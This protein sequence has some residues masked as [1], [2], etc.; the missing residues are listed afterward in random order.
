MQPKQQLSEAEIKI[1]MNRVIKEGLTA[2]TVTTLTSGAFLVA[3]ALKLGAS[4]FQIGILASLPTICN[5][6][7]LIAI[8]FLQKYR[9]RRIISA[10]SAFLARLPL[11]V[12]ALLPFV[13][14]PQIS[15]I[16]LISMLFL[17]FFF[18]T[19]T[20]LSWNSWMK[21]LIPEAK[22]GTYF[23]QRSRLIQ[24]LNVTISVSVA[25]SLDHI[26]EFFPDY[27]LLTYSAMFLLASLIGFLGVYLFARTPEPKMDLSEEINI[28]SFY[29]KPL[30]DVNFRNFL[31]FNSTWAF[32]TNLAI[33][34]FAVYL[35][36]TLHLKLSLIIGLN[37]LSQISSILFIK[38]WGKYCD[39]FSNKTILSFCAP[40]YIAS[41]LIWPYTTMPESHSLTIYLLLVIYGLIGI[42]SAGINLS[43]ANIG[44]KLTPKAETVTYLS[45]RSMI[46]AFFTAI[47][48]IIGGLFAD[49][50]SG[51]KLTWN[52]EWKGTTGNY[53][54]PFI[55]LES[56][57]FF[58]VIG[59][60]VAILSLKMLTKVTEEGEVHKKVLIS[61]LRTGLKNG[62]RIKP[63][64]LMGIMFRPIE[65]NCIR[66]RKSFKKTNY[67]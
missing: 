16:M 3:L 20:N 23:S 25:L 59:A 2:E 58:F 61:E 29:K 31:V 66:M 4:N 13:F 32:A 17:H 57:D 38:L 46:T 12:V 8:Y 40:L 26:K 42:S 45:T 54:L 52:I 51:Q 49:F 39:R 34:F 67:S 18:S 63:S 10:V 11:I 9:N 30:K 7:Q 14:S 24:I 36:Q 21:D 55:N 19:I 6:F 56:W 1:G 60:I 5:V 65:I 37:M 48:P 62:V 41:M 44:Y 15:L 47:A 27:E 43:L 28:F 33:P 64:A 35:M 50:F 53:T 22:L